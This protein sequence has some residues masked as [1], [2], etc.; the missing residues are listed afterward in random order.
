MKGNKWT[1]EEEVK[2][3]LDEAICSTEE[4]KDRYDEM[5]DDFKL[6]SKLEKEA[7]TNLDD[8][9]RKIIKVVQEFK[10]D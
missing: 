2:D 10:N 3:L 4:F 9:V 6:V 8:I 1:L 5:E 7:D